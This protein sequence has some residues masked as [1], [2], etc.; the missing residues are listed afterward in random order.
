MITDGD[1]KHASFA[2]GTGS[3]GFTRGHTVANS[4]C[5]ITHG[6][7]PDYEG[8]MVGSGVETKDLKKR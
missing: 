6:V 2:H 8:E 5:C 4:D 3:R 7:H 1:M